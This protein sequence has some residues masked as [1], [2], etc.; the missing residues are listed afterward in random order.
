MAQAA[1]PGLSSRRL[2][3]VRVRFVADKLAL[4][5]VLSEFFGFPLSL[6]FLRGSRVIYLWD[7][8]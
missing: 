7:E 3:S 4:G 1:V 5:Q 8:Q 6:S 2:V